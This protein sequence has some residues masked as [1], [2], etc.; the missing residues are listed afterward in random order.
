MTIIT[1]PGLEPGGE[2]LEREIPGVG[3]LRFENYPAGTWLTQKGTPGKR[4]RR[5]YLLDGVEL[6]SVSSIVDTLRK[7]GLEFWKEDMGARGAVKAERLGELVDVPED[8]I[9]KRVRLLQLGA[10]AR[11]GEGADRGNAIHDA[12]HKLAVKKKIPNP[13]DFPGFARPWVQGAMRAWM[14]LDPGKVIAAEEIVCHP[15]LGY[16]G[17]PDLVAMCQGKPTVIDYKTSSKGEVYDSAHYQTRL[18]SMALRAM[19]VPIERVVIVGIGDD[20][21]CELIECETSEIATE[22]LILLFRDRKR[23]NSGMSSQRAIARAAA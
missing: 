22:A 4:P 6:D 13:A 17:R 2:T 18:Y 16:A 14:K 9:I 3:L 20:G 7:I 12:F 23:V 5:R 11:A 15:E 1:P 19:G 21:K 10:D 8:E